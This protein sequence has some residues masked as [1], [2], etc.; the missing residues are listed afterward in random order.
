MIERLYAQGGH[1]PPGGAF[2]GA[3]PGAHPPAAPPGVPPGGPPGVGGPV[4]MA[5]PPPAAAKSKTGL[6][7]GVGCVSL[8][9]MGL[10]VGGGV[11]FY[12]DYKRQQAREQ[13]ARALQ[14]ALSEKGAPGTTTSGDVCAVTKRCCRAIAAKSGGPNTHCDAYGKTGTVQINCAQALQGFKT[15]ATALGITCN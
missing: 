4:P 8:F 1:P 9:V 2:P 6:W 12:L 10:L 5:A 7:I 15:A 11:Y 13:A 3:P 14:G